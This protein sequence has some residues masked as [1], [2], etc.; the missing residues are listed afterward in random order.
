MRRLLAGFGIVGIA[1]LLWSVL[2]PGQAVPSTLPG[3][4][5]GSHE[6]HQAKLNWKAP[7][8]PDAEQP[9]SY[10]IYRTN[11]SVKDRV[12]KCG[13]KWRRI[14][15]MAADVTEYT[16][17]EVKPGKAYCYAV[18]AITSR[19]ESSKSFTATAVIPSP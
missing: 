9:M 14:A 8:G 1:I 16:D 13:K 11:A 18:S 4:D 2:V 19:G 7:T 6:K 5:Q 12:V 10:V 3:S 15:S 17:E